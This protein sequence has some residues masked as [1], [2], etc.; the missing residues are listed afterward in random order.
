M[1]ENDFK[2]SVGKYGP[3][4]KQCY[5]TLPDQK[6]VRDLLN[7]L[8][9]HLGGAAGTLQGPL[10]WGKVREDL[11]QA[12]I[13]FQRAH[14]EEGLS[15][16]GHVDPH[17]K[18]IRLLLRLAQTVIPADPDIH[19][20]VPPSAPIPPL[21][22]AQTTPLSQRFKIRY[23]GGASLGPFALHRFDIWDVQNDLTALYTLEAGGFSAGTPISVT[24]AGEFTPFTTNTDTSIK[25]FGGPASFGDAGGGDNSVSLLTL[26]VFSPPLVL[27]IDTGFTQGFDVVAVTGGVF[28]LK[29]FH[30]G[31]PPVIPFPGL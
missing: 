4:Q 19:P 27:K 28:F 22:P 23:H 20:D 26:F 31:P 21:P 13:K 1:D 7:K 6:M 30:D 8:P 17:Q 16:D 14:P 15:V 18:T 12:F 11:Y 24:G 29:S 9:A 2:A 5:N 3:D 10:T 25:N